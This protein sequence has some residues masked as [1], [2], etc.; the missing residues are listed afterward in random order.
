MA[1]AFN[2]GYSYHD[3]P[4]ADSLRNRRAT[5]FSS[6]HDQKFRG[7]AEGGQLLHTLS[8]QKF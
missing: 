1:F 5:G 6:Y 2:K 4:L 7:E 8:Q 3:R